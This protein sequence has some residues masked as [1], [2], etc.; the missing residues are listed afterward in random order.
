MNIGENKNEQYKIIIHD[1]HIVAGEVSESTTELYGDFAVA[2]DG[3]VIRYNE[4][5]GDFA[6]TTTH[7]SVLGPD[8]LH[9]SRGGSYGLSFLLEKGKRHNCFYDTPYGRLEMGVYAQRIDSAMND[10]GGNLSF[11]YSLD[12][13]GGEVSE[14]EL[15]VEV[16]ELRQK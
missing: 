5:E 1:R 14:N 8:S 4:H 15:E 13:G 7:I 6:G 11:A 9:L 12:I 2:Q 16:K 3:Y 10:K